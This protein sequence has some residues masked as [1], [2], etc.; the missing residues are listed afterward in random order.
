MSVLAANALSVASEL[1][2]ASATQQTVNR[3]P[4]P[5]PQ[6]SQAVTTPQPAEPADLG[7]NALLTFKQD[8]TGRVYYV[9]TNAQT[10]KEIAQLPPEELRNVEDGIAGYLQEQ[11][12]KSAAATHIETKA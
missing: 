1:A 2:Q 11:E 5:A 10:G 7:L 3:T 6:E 4:A 12:A 8:P 9:V